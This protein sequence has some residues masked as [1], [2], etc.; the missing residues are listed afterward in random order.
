[1]KRSNGGLFRMSEQA[2]QQG[3]NCL[4]SFFGFGKKNGFRFSGVI[5]GIVCLNIAPLKAAIINPI[6]FKANGGDVVRNFAAFDADTGNS[7]LIFGKQFSILERVN[8]DGLP[9]GDHGLN[10][11][12]EHSFP[13]S[14][15]SPSGE[16]MSQP[17]TNDAAPDVDKDNLKPVK[18]GWWVHLVVQFVV[19]MAVGFF[20]YLA[21]H[22]S[23]RKPNQ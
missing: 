17:R 12:T 4:P 21:G 13:T 2:T 5:A 10:V 9:F 8:I 7:R 6:V 22:K 11:S 16:K 20:A 15:F 1:M 19:S 18:C 23:R 3:N 14:G